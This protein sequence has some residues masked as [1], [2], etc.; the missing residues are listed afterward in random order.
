MSKKDYEAIAR[1]IV[2]ACDDI[3]NKEPDASQ[4]DMIDGATLAAEHIA[5]YC[6]RTSE[7]FDRARFL[8]ACGVNE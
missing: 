5:D 1:A 6:R 7:S 8:K 4:A 2:A 3:R